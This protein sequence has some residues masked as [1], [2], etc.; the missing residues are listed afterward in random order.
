MCPLRKFVSTSKPC[1]LRNFLF[2]PKLH[3]H[4]VTL[5]PPETVCTAKLSIHPEIL[6]SLRNLCF[7]SVTFMFTPC[8]FIHPLRNFCVHPLTLW[9]T[10]WRSWL[11][12]RVTSRKVEGSIPHGVNGI[13]HKPNPSDRFMALGWTQS[14]T[15]MSTR[16][17]RRG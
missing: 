3:V 16:D 17:I 4:A 14:L 7:H 9:V 11:R 15:E 12:Y 6:C 5:C 2:T 13:F 1:P 10:R 8:N